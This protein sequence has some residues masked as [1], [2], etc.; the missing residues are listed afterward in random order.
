M[1]KTTIAVL[2]AV[3]FTG[4][5]L[6]RADFIEVNKSTYW[7]KIGLQALTAALDANFGIIEDGS[8][9]VALD[10]GEIWVGNAS[11]EQAAV[12][13]SGGATMDTNGVVTLD[14]S[15]PGTIGGTTPAVATFTT[16]SANVLMSTPVT[17]SVTNGQEV[18][19]A[20]SV[21]KLEATEVA[22]NT[23]ANPSLVGHVAVLANTGT[24]NITIAKGANVALGAATRVIAPNGTLSLVAISST[25]WLEIANSIDNTVE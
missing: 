6:A 23:L 2:F 15:A 9:T 7:G 1:K 8:Y 11:D 25:R 22:T 17:V 13:M 4:A 18:V 14:L 19:I 10:A 12:A 20:S 5:I 21:V 16:A 24:N 3:L